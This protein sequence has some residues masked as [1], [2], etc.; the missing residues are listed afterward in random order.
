MWFSLSVDII[1]KSGQEGVCD[2]WPRDSACAGA[3]V[4]PY[5]YNPWQVYGL[6]AFPAIL[7]NVAT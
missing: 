7:A 5:V 1:A 3:N 6:C 2:I 4:L